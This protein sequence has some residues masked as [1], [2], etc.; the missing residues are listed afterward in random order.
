MPSIYAR[1]DHVA[2]YLGLEEMDSTAAVE[3]MA[4][5]AK[6]DFD[7]E[8]KRPRDFDDLERCGLPAFK[9][10]MWVA[11][12]RFIGRPWFRRVWIVQECVVAKSVT[13][14]WAEEW[15]LPFETLRIFVM[16]CLKMGI[17]VL[18]VNCEKCR[19]T[20]R[21]SRY[22]EGVELPASFS[23]PA[24]ELGTW[25]APRSTCHPHAMQ[26]CRGHV[27]EGQIFCAGGIVESSGQ[28]R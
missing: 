17:P 20:C 8:R 21:R 1:A 4:R 6:C 25:Q 3:L 7:D 23:E 14:F 11:L 13:L 2:A 12:Q 5:L 10:A 24:K 18:Q 26:R 19:G 9:D 27:E 28:A 15:S 22:G 16:Q